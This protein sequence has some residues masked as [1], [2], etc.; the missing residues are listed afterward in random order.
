M[1]AITRARYLRTRA[2]RVLT[3]LVRGG[4]PMLVPLLAFPEVYR[5]TALDLVGLFDP[6]RPRASIGPSRPRLGS[7]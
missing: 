7:P 3:L 4:L 2:Q 5:S 6:G 1:L